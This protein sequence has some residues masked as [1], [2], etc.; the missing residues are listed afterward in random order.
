MNPIKVQLT[1]KQGEGYVIPL[2]PVNLVNVITDKGMVGLW[3]F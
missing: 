2:G 3:G 1:R